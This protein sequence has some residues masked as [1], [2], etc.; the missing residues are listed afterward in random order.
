MCMFFI[1][2]PANFCC[3]LHN[4]NISR[5]TRIQQVACVCVC[6]CVC[7]CVCVCIVYCVFV[8]ELDNDLWYNYLWQ[9]I[10]DIQLSILVQKFKLF[11]GM[12]RGDLADWVSEL[13]E[14]RAHCSKQLTVKGRCVLSPV[15]FLRNDPI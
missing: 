7:L 3:T 5:N 10:R 1:L 12:S 9:G 13:G 6:V 14:G 11:V 2:F 15:I 4:T 8:Q